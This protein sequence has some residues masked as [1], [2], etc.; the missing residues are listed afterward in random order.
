MPI[1]PA[2]PSVPASRTRK[3][4][5][6]AASPRTTR[7]EAREN[8]VN[9]LGGAFSL[10]AVMKGWYADAGAVATH[11]PRF[12]KELALVADSN[13][14][15]G[16]WLD[17]LTQGGPWVGVV[18]AG[19]PLLLQLSANH[20]RIDATKLP[21]DSGIVEPKILEERVRAEMRNASARV[22]AEIREIEQQTATLERQTL[23]E[24]M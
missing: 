8:A 13:E 19:L 20:G 4:S 6:A 22:L 3:T 17:Y 10:I 5:I 14:Q 2:R 23:R 11:G 16:T 9:E 18:K 12:A 7:R 21:P 15:V 24:A 1:E